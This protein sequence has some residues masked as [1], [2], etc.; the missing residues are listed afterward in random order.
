M[1]EELPSN[2]EQ[3]GSDR[4]KGGFITDGEFYGNVVGFQENKFYIMLHSLFVLKRVGVFVVLFV[5]VFLVGFSFVI[6][7]DDVFIYSGSVVDS[8]SKKP[9]ALADIRLEVPGI[10]EILTRSDSFGN[11][12]F[13]VDLALK[14]S[15]GVLRV[16]MDGYKIYAQEINLPSSSSYI[17]DIQLAPVV[18]HSSGNNQDN[19]GAVSLKEP[20]SAPSVS[21]RSVEDLL[22]DAERAVKTEGDFFKAIDILESAARMYPENFGVRVALGRL[23]LKS[24]NKDRIEYIDIAIYHLEKA[25]EID[26][27]HFDGYYNIANVYYYY[28]RERERPDFIDKAIENMSKAIVIN[29]N[30]KSAWKGRG[31]FYIAKG[32]FACSAIDDLKM[33]LKVGDE[34]GVEYIAVYYFIAEAYQQ[35]GDID[36]TKTYLDLFAVKTEHVVDD[37]EIADLKKSMVNI[38]SDME[39][40]NGVIMTS[41]VC[42]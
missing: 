30:N 7:D 27:S 41:I 1:N 6:N 15:K 12:H 8:I 4:R 29:R 22:S 38:K 3:A 40:N 28:A 42:N 35:I 25:I 11:Y 16:N 14:E 23:Y 37:G 17:G 31:Q 32:G 21:V 9:V 2:L 19:L 24:Y 13:K 10:Q 34:E 26:P 20:T 33:A 5:L 36:G 18:L 39:R